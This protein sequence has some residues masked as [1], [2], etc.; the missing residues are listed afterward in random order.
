VREVTAGEVMAGFVG[1]QT[2]SRVGI[3]VSTYLPTYLSTYLSIYLPIYLST[4]LS[5]Y[6][7]V[8]L[9]IY[10]SIYH[11][12]PVTAREVMAGFVGF[13]TVS[14]VGIKATSGVGNQH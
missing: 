9:S 7:S 4:Y 2:V 6:L 1:I 14:R 10:L 5:I 8:Y 11:T 12:V 13:Q 3:N